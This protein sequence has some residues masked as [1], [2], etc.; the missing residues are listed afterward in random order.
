MSECR[1]SGCTKSATWRVTFPDATTA[2]YCWA[3]AMNLQHVAESTHHAGVQLEKLD[4]ARAAAEPL[5][6]RD[7]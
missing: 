2:V 1:A 4:D 5:E 7:P 6:R 3:C